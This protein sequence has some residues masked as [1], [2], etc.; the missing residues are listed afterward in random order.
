MTL[1]QYEFARYDYG[2][3]INFKIYEEDGSTAFD[4]TGLTGVVKGF[5]RHGDRAFFFRDVAKALTVLGSVAQIIGDI[6]IVWD[7]QASG[8]GHFS[9]TQNARP[10]ING[11]LWLEVQMVDSP[12][13][14]QISTELVR[15]FVTPS[16]GA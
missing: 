13:T 6:D 7:T 9:F 14:K 5:K 10:S 11:M 15:V 3:Q 4:A 1:D 12:K 2:R 16:E 8:V